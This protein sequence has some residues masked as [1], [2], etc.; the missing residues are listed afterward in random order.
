MSTAS[1]VYGLLGAGLLDFLFGLVFYATASVLLLFHTTL[2]PR[3]L[4]IGPFR[5]PRGIALHRLE[6]F[7][8]V[9]TLVLL[10]MP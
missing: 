2:L 4:R 5:F 9:H 1:R 3:S 6:F 8:L 10:R 7:F